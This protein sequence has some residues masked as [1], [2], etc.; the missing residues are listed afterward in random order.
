M[1]KIA[2]DWTTIDVAS[3]NADQQEAYHAYKAAYKVMK[4]EREFFEGVM[5]A[6]VPAGERMIFGYN[7][8][9]LSIAIVPDDRKPVKA[10]QGTQSLA[11]Y[12]A[13]RKQSGAQC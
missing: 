6:D 5:A 4:A 7:F 3:L 2:A 12:L 13:Q 9:K 8:G 11:D 10:K 1:T